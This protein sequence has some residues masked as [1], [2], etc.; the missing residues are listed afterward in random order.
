MRITLDGRAGK[1]QASGV[2]VKRK[3]VK[4]DPVLFV[5][6]TEHEL[7]GYEKASTD[8]GYRHLS[9]WVRQA[10]KKYIHDGVDTR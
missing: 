2:K 4:A 6:V 10:L 8:A 5:R 3:T 1:G 7:R 9:E